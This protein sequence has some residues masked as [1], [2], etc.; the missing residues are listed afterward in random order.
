MQDDKKKTDEFVPWE[1][2][3]G[4][5]KKAERGDGIPPK[6]NIQSRV[7]SKPKT[8]GQDYLDLYIR[9]KEKERTEKYG[10][11]LAKQLKDTAESWRDVKKEMKEKEEEMHNEAQKSKEGSGEK[12]NTENKQGKK[13]PTHMK[14][15][16]WNY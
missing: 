15:M 6:T 2:E 11:I 1:T 12:P 8:D 4:R 16:N 3:E 5:K 9:S 14:K 7:H 10:G 13:P